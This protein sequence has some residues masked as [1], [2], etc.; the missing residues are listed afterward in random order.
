MT[1]KNMQSYDIPT[2]RDTIKQ[3]DI[4]AQKDWNWETFPF[5]LLHQFGWWPQGLKMLPEL[6]AYATDEAWI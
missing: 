5:P 6:F 2:T 3:I 1:Y 4:R